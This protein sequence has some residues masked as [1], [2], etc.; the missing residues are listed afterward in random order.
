MCNFKIFLLIFSKRF[1]NK[2]IIILILV[3]II[4]MNYNKKKIIFIN[5]D[6]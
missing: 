4:I 6:I 5:Y 1:I 2:L 3:L